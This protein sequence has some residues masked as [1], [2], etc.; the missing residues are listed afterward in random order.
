[1]KIQN[2]SLAVLSGLGAPL[3]L[4]GNPITEPKDLPNILWIT[5]ED[6]S[7]LLGCY[8][9]PFATT[10]NLDKLASKGF[11]Y[12]H[13][14]SNA[15]VCAP[16]RNTIITGT[17][18]CSGGNQYMRSTYN[19][20]EV[21]KLFPYY[22]RQAGYYCTNCLK[23]D[24]N[25][26][27]AQTKGVWDESGKDAHYKNRQKGQPFFAVFNSAISHESCLFKNIPDD[28]LRHK[29]QDVV[30]PPYHPDTPEMRHDWAQY[31]D[32]IED[33]DTWVGEKLKELEESGELE[34]T[35]VFYYSDHGG[36][37]ARSK[38]YLY[39]TG[40]HVPFIVY[41]PEKYKHL[42]PA[43]SPGSKVDRLISFV[44][45]APTLLSIIG[46]DIPDY[47][48]GH[49]FLGSQ[50]TAAPEYNFM[51]RDRMDERYDMSR[52]VCDKKYRYIR[53]YMP[54][55]IYGQY[56]E[57]LWRAPSVGSWEKF[58][59]EGKCNQVQSQFWSTK[60]AEELYD[61]END[62][63]EVNNLAAN[64][65]YKDILERMRKANREWML[66]I[67][68]TGFIPEAELTDIVGDGA[69][70]NYMRSGK[71]NLEKLI[72]AAD[73]ATNAKSQDIA[74][75]VSLLK[76][77]Y[78]PVRYWGATGL[79]LL[80][81]KAGPVKKEIEKAINDSS[82][83]VTIVLAETLYGLG[84]KEQGKK[85]L[86]A[87]LKS[88]N[89]FARVHAFNVIDEVDENSPEIQ[90][91]VIQSLKGR[92]ELDRNRVDDRCVRQLLAKWKINPKDY[93]IEI[94]W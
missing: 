75:L 79:L 30:L 83:N 87:A 29:P 10:P 2:L 46:V 21:V 26:N 44:D 38:R 6:N 41:I 1:M 63:W 18:A 53:N 12:T 32:K 8:G 90:Q 11:L 73:L 28:K 9:D 59:N 86:L 15:P 78:A 48:Q 77:N 35:I 34:N 69:A 13:A 71:V 39:E 14:Y 54:Y 58:Y 92:Q 85:G 40:T 37:L 43:E 50:K 64:P 68:D 91:A 4:S 42:Y 45:L 80:G 16:S 22:L 55:C 3:L 94:D 57:Y 88:P 52:A 47:I 17:Y 62:P 60:P 31:Y 5:S 74:E 66:K 70:Y 81:G 51:F 72:D 67:K 23:Q 7:P 25:I 65:E 33:L 84:E 76:S 89:S 93:N 20:S 61:T 19:K 49:A 27:P 56:L 82:A 24:Y 36:V